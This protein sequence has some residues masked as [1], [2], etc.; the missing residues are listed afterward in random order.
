[1]SERVLPDAIDTER[2]GASVASSMRWPE[3]APLIVYLHG[4]LGSGKTTLAR[5]LLRELGVAGTVRSPTYTLLEQYESQGYRL[6]HL[7]LYRLGNALDLAP[8]GLR[9]ELTPGALMLIEWPERAQGYLPPPDLK[10]TLTMASVGRR[11]RIEPSGP[12]GNEWLSRLMAQGDS[13]TKR[14]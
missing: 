3:T 5:G 8:L 12:E 13:E 11:V 14:I 9:D 4:E 6:L 1:L 10:I 2:L 7:D